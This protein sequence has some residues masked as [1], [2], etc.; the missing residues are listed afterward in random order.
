MWKKLFEVIW[1]PPE[2]QN[3]IRA[4]PEFLS[5]GQKQTRLGSPT[6]FSRSHFSLRRKFNLSNVLLTFFKRPWKNRFWQ[7][8]TS[9]RAWDFFL[10]HRAKNKSFQT[11]MRNSR[12]RIRQFARFHDWHDFHQI[13]G[14]FIATVY[15]SCSAILRSFLKT[16]RNLF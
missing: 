5:N 1:N 8:A 3:G 4:L 2:M 11:F 16:S 15:I 6:R 7:T 14:A 10:W 12:P 13:G 9:F